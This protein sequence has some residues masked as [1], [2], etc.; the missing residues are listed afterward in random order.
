MPHSYVSLWALTTV[1][2]QVYSK[3]WKGFYGKWHEECI[4][5][6]GGS[7]VNHAQHRDNY[8]ACKKVAKNIFWIKEQFWQKHRFAGIGASTPKGFDQPKC[9]QSALATRHHTSPYPDWHSYF[10]ICLWWWVSQKE[11]FHSFTDPGDCW[12]VQN[13]QMS[14]D[15]KSTRCTT[16]FITVSAFFISLSPCRSEF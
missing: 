3:C 15:H 4:N 14:D 2:T 1:T 11:I 5:S 10:G 12:V 6:M 9:C 8:Y 7:I 16:M 13:L